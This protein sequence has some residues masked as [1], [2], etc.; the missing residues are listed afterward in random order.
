MIV[1]IGIFLFC[2]HYMSNSDL[3]LGCLVW[4]QVQKVQYEE[5]WQN[6]EQKDEGA[7]EATL[8]PFTSILSRLF[9]LIIQLQGGL[10]II[11][12]IADD[13][14]TL[15]W[16]AI[17]TIFGDHRVSS[18]IHRRVCERVP[19]LT[20]VLHCHHYACLFV[21]LIEKFNLMITCERISLGLQIILIKI[22]VVTLLG[23]ITFLN[24]FCG[25]FL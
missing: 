4:I 3:I 16:V 5:C 25:F 22:I 19:L 17:T 21:L 13:L 9:L 6:D 8:A 11:Q 12:S 20:T 7:K 15:F 2:I 1:G 10:P 23:F 14:I 18:S 24:N